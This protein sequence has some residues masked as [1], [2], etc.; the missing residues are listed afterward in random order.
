MADL[1]YASFIIGTKGCMHARKIR[2]NIWNGSTTVQEI[3]AT[4]PLFYSRINLIDADCKKNIFLLL[5]NPRIKQIHQKLCTVQSHLRLVIN[6]SYISEDSISHNFF[7]Y[8][9][10]SLV[11]DLHFGNHCDEMSLEAKVPLY[12]IVE[13]KRF[14]FI[15]VSNSTVHSW[16]FT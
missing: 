16:S 6:P 14:F 7:K 5:V 4:S 13:V 10:V 8:K 2:I 12:K 3:E 11:S 1:A 15:S 9:L